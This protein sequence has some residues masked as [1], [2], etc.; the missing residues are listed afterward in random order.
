M[1]DEKKGAL[2]I[3][4][5]SGSQAEH[6]PHVQRSCGRKELAIRN[7]EKKLRKYGKRDPTVLRGEQGDQMGPELTMMR[8]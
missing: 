4:W 5:G 3:E 6:L 8:S 2:L 1:R 7:D